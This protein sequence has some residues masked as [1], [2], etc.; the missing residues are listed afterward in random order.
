VGEKIRLKDSTGLGTWEILLDP[1][2]DRK[3]GILKWERKSKNVNYTKEVKE[4]VREPTDS[5]K[6]GRFTR[7]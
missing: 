6:L 3:C 1:W 2:E 4:V 7:R 5:W